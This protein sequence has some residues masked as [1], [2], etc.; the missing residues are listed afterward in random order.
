MPKDID[1]MSL[2][3]AARQRRTQQTRVPNA[4]EGPLLP[5]SVGMTGRGVASEYER[6]VRFVDP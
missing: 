1:A 4:E 6:I 2:P 5:G 3:S